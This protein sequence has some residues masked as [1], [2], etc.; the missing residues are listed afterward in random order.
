MAYSIGF[1]IFAKDAA[2]AVFKK[3]GDNVQGTEGKFSSMKGK[4]VAAAAVAGTAVIAFAGSAVDK[5]KQVGGETLALMRTLGGTPESMSRLR[6]A[7]TQSGVSIETLQKST[8]KFAKALDAAKASTKSQAAMTKLLGTSFLDAKGHVLPMND[9]IGKVSDKFKK[10][11]AGPEKTALAMKL[12]GKAGADMLPFLNKGSTGIGELEKASDKYGL[13]LSGKMLDSLKKSKAGQRD[14][15]ATLDGLK[16]QVGAQILPILTTFAGFIRDRVI[17]IVQAITG[18]MQKHAGVMKI[19]GIVLV[20]LVAGLKAWSIAQAILNAVMAMNPIALVV[21][22]IA[23]LAAG[24]IYAYKHSETFRNIVQGAF[25]GVK[26]AV[27]IMWSIVK[28]IFELY[29]GEIKIVAAVVHWLYD[30]AVKP[31]FDQISSAASFMW[32]NVLKP[33][34][35]WLVEGFLNVAGSIVHG[36]ATM[37]GWVPEIGGKLKSAAKNFDTFRDNVNKSLDGITNPK[38]VSIVPKL[39]P[40]AMFNASYMLDSLTAQRTVTINAQTGGHFGGAN[41][42]RA[43]GGSVQKGMPYIV[44]EKRPELFIPDENGSIVPNLADMRPGGTAGQSAAAPHIIQVDIHVGGSV[45]AERDLI[46]TISAGI[47]Q[48]Q[49]RLGVPTIYGQ[50]A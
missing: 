41:G 38:S 1:D 17:P 9:L 23:A 42:A 25:A 47:E 15:N 48:A 14:W 12:F 31:A 37:F 49:K 11:P 26:T 5:F 29:V 39:D 45:V 50:R 20:T 33:T 13:T 21:I 4:V 40:G 8:G 22:A 32:N 19:V 7:A 24:L 44:G 28:P 2:S 16:V 10:M 30:H 6:F 18:F 46:R 35:R 27:G 36:A 3:L 43:L 34:F